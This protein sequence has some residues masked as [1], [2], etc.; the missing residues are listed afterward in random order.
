MKAPLAFGLRDS[1]SALA[2][3]A[4]LAPRFA[5]RR[6]TVSATYRSPQGGGWIADR[7]VANTPLNAMEQARATA[8]LA[9]LRRL[10]VGGAFWGP[11]PTRLPRPGFILLRPQTPAGATAMVE[12]TLAAAAAGSVLVAMPD[13]PWSRRLKPRLERTGLTVHLGP[14]APWPLLETA[15]AVEVE[16]EDP[17]GLLALAAGVDLICVGPCDLSGWGLSSDR[18]PVPSRGLRT[19]AQVA[20]AVLLTGTVYRNPFTGRATE[21]E[22]VIAILGDWRRRL[23][24]NRRIGCG[25]GMA[26]WKRSAL[27]AMLSAPEQKLAFRRTAQAAVQTARARSGGVA[28]WASRRPPR[29][30]EA[31]SRA[32]IPLLYVEDGFLRSAGLGAE[33]TPPCSIVVDTV[34]PHYAPDRRTDIERILAETAFEPHLLARA[35]RIIATLNQHRLTKYNVGASAPIGLPRNRRIVL[36]PGQVEDDLSVKLGGAGVGGNLALLARVRAMEP[37][38]LILY[39]PHPDVEGGHRHGAIADLQAL[40]H[41]DR[42]V[43]GHAID[44]LLG[45]VDAVHVLTSLAGFEA[46]LRGCEVVV[47]GQPFYAGWGLTRDVIPILRRQRR[48]SLQELVAGA[49]ILY[50]IYLD[51][52]TRLPCPPE[53]LAMRLAQA[54]PR[55]TLIN[56]AR[57][58]QGRLRRALNPIWLRSVA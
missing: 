3:G 46:L 23:D 10:Q 57:R 21:C 8:A 17:M 51:P 27:S 34:A 48:L 11:P 7:L 37:E 30:A 39:K 4:L 28:V 6:P 29:L 15:G 41:A 25:A 35:D 2:P 56:R 47:H 54:A 14:C 18:A 13:R 5:R 20:H 49:L 33:F 55:L 22:D 53:I 44:S 52:V 50:P 43:R 1:W 9:S 31:A 19:L 40:R 42:I 24:L 38:A 58:L 32:Q 26:I 45:Q 12:H 16:G 36:V